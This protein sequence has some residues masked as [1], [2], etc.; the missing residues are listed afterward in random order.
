[1]A[2]RPLVLSK[3]ERRVIAYH[4]G[5]H[6]LVALLTSGADPVHKVTIVPHGQA[7]GATEMV[8]LDDRHNYAPAYLMA[9]L[10]VGLGGRVAEEQEIGEITT[11]AEN[12]LK[13]V[14]QL[15]R[16]MVTRWGMSERLGAVFLGGE[17]EVFLGREVGLREQ[18]S[19]SEETAAVIDEEVQQ[20][21]GERYSSVQ[22]LLSQHREELSRIAEA[23]LERETLDAAQLQ[24]VLKATK[25]NAEP[26]QEREAD[27]AI[28]AATARQERLRSQAFPTGNA[29]QDEFLPFTGDERSLKSYMLPGKA[30]GEVRLCEGER[31]KNEERKTGMTAISLQ[32]LDEHTLTELHRR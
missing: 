31:W 7:L 20:L 28:P 22:Q 19:Y 21:I 11:G 32:P 15:V 8:P 4:E 14:T 16:E 6:T 1:M 3:E 25:S 30:R 5:G 29:R 17:Q 18:H 26:M 2:E 13:Q 12:D 24:Q 23:L 9:R 10:A 27:R